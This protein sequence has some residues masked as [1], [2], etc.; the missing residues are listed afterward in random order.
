MQQAVHEGSSA[1][2]SLV[3]SDICVHPSTSVRTVVEKFFESPQIEAVGVVEGME[4]VGLLTRQKLLFSVFRRYG[5]ELYGR[6]PVIMITDTEP[7]YIRKGAS[8]RRDQQGPCKAFPGRVHLQ[9][10]PLRTSG[11]GGTLS[12]P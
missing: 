1:V 10:G 7:L 8:R 12:Y 3:A 2:G 4:A 11:K 9:G 6:K 5:F